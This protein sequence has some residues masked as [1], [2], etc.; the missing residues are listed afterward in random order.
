MTTPSIPPPSQLTVHSKPS[1]P[2][3]YTFIPPSP[4]SPP[5]KNLIVFINGLGLP[6]ASWKPTLIHLLTQP[7]HPALLTYDRF[8][9]GL[10]TSRDPLD[11]TP[12]KE[13]GHNFQDIANDLH[14][15]LQVVAEKEFQSSR[16]EDVN[17]IM[18]G[19]SIGCPIIRLYIATHPGVVSGV[20]FLDS[21]IPHLNYSD[22]LPDPSA[23][24][25][26]RASVIA[27]D[28]TLPQYIGARLALC[29]M[30]D[31]DA[32]NPE[33]ID[34]TQGPRLLPEAENP[35]LVGKDGRMELVVVGH[36]PETFAS[37]SL[38]RM[39]TPKSLSEK[40]TN[41]YWAGYNEGL[42]RLVDDG[43]ERKV[44]IA[45]GCG[46]FIQSDDPTFVGEEIVKMSERIGW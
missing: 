31:L 24:N 11:G 29:K 36:D 30:F 7:T 1:A 37:M 43:K 20:I 34:R 8:G 15:L 4:P 44:T 38:E 28:C 2:I 23:P 3:S 33:G 16:I 5:S 26:D 21:N 18:V 19:A 46:H 12:G 13:R 17:I 22:F 9:Q 42:T 25:F 39:G 10:T 40:F 45:K 32:K 41:K 35:K 14:S 6:A 27:E